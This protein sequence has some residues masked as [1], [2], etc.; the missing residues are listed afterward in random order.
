M[1]DMPLSD[2][3]GKEHW[4]ETYNIILLGGYCTMVA[5]PDNSGLAR[6]VIRN[7]QVAHDSVSGHPVASGDAVHR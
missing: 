6:V 3:Y 7:Q 4:L 5:F 2:K 1:D